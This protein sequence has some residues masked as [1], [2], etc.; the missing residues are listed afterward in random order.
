MRVLVSMGIKA[1]IMALVGV[2]MALTFVGNIFL[3]LKVIEIGDEIE[4]VAE[5]DMPLVEMI[6]KIEVHQLEQAVHFERAL[7]LNLEGDSAKEA[8]KKEIDA[9]FKL[10]KKVDQELLEA[11]EVI[12]SFLKLDSLSQ[13][14]RD[15]MEKLLKS[16][17]KLEHEH[18]EYDDHAKQIFDGYAQG[19]T[20]QDMA[21]L[22]HKTEEEEKQI[23]KEVEA[24]LFEIA[25]F[26]KAALVE[27]EHHEH[28]LE[29]LMM[30]ITV[31]ILIIGLIIGW[32]LGGNIAK[33]MEGVST[34]TEKLA[35]GDLQ[36]D[37][38]SLELKNEIGVIARALLVFRENLSEMEELRETSEEEKRQAEE[39]QRIA[40]NQ[41][42]DSFEQDVGT[43]VQTV[44]SAA[45]ELQASS[46]QMSHTAAQ[47][48]TQAT[49]VATSSEQAS[50]N[51]ETVA[52]ATEEL[53]ASIGEIRNQ[54]ALS[55]EVSDRAVSVASETT[56]TIEELSDSVRKIGEVVHMITEIADQTNLLA[57]NATIEAARAGD[58]GKGFAVVAGEV[59]NLANQTSKATEEITAQIGHVQSGTSDAVHAIQSI[60]DVITQINDIS[61]SVATSVEEQSAATD[62][63]AQNIE[64]ASNGTRNVSES[65]KDVERGASETGSA[66]SQIES[67]ST[68]LS[69]QAE[70]LRE[71]V[72]S[73]LDRVRSDDNGHMSI[74]EWYAELSYGHDQIDQGHMAF[75]DAVNS[76]YTHMI[77]GGKVKDILENLRQTVD[78]AADH[79]KLEI[80][81]LQDI[82]YP[83]IEQVK[84]DQQ[85][86][87]NNME[88]WYQAYASGNGEDETKAF[89][90]L[91]GW[92]NGHI[93]KM[94]TAYIRQQLAA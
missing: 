28:A 39:R 18:K 74:I 6:S 69:M 63:I 13:K 72:A 85:E 35:K 20:S 14:E 59:K 5:R 54:V 29:K 51:V 64:G 46:S 44:T 52:A 84:A 89:A 31:G 73:F 80:Q 50:A 70:F 86:F 66:A 38:P 8:L 78:K 9:F 16:I 60:S 68:D 75:I 92:F 77:K 12:T 26:T 33:L 90:G 79:F 3:E 83:G 47:T 30:A 61:T 81:I 7:R 56:H 40:L 27:A 32:F 2:L 37:I 67:A 45:T 10:A 34:A 24:L 41:M 19:K 43:V 15:E 55:S 4:A 53:T 65:I 87:L 88:R 23:T 11:D 42:A 91:L 25:A 93:E 22:I 17:K 76:V 1:K 57:L 94:D 71:K 49:S 58:A 21:E 36:A 62:E 48:S 82:N